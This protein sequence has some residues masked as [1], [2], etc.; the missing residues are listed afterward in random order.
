M[1]MGVVMGVNINKLGMWFALYHLE[2]Q[3]WYDVDSNGGRSTHEFY[4]NDGLYAVGRNRFCGRD[5]IR[6]FYDWRRGRGQV[7]TRHLVT[8]VNLIAED[9]R[10]A[11]SVG[12]LTVYRVRGG[13]YRVDRRQVLTKVDGPVLVADF[14]SDC[15]LGADDVWR[16]QSHTID[17]VFVDID[18]PFSLAVDPQYLSE[19][20]Y[21]AC[22]R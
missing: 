15:V 11:K 5:S 9:E 10:R 8:N 13:G 21:T 2:C 1:Q 20:S 14:E 17:P 7:I 3:H 16:Y 22:N 12:L 4:E 18:A 6:N 19:R